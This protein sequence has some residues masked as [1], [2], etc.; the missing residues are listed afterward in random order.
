MRTRSLR[1]TAL[2]LCA[3]F[4][5]AVL[6]AIGLQ[7][8]HSNHHCETGHCPLCV[9]YTGSQIVMRILGLAAVLRAL[10]MLKRLPP[11]L[12]CAPEI[13]VLLLA[14]PVSLSI[15]MND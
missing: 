15:R 11:P 1:R 2:I 12:P 9:A 8:A 14:S 4:A 13:P 5:L 3:V 10:L 7:Y 6:A